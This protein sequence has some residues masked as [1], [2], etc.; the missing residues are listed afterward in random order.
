LPVADVSGLF[1]GMTEHGPSRAQ[2]TAGRGV[3]CAGGRQAVC[4]GATGSVLAV[5]GLPNAGADHH[6]VYVV[7][8]GGDAARLI[9]TGVPGHSR[10]S[11]C[12]IGTDGSVTVEA[13]L[14]QPV[15]DYLG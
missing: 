15:S 4:W 6:D 10:A 14:S 3:V 13:D 9:T 8:G 11:L 1:A 12:R 2:V 5:R 7:D